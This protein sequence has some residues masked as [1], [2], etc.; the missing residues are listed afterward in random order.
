MSKVGLLEAY[1]DNPAFKVWLELVMSI[2]LLPTEDIAITWEELKN[3]D[4]PN[5]GNP[6]DKHFRVSYF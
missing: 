2:P 5:M 3:Q 4:I 1:K 6:V